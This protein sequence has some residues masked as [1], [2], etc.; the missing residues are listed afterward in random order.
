[1]KQ[2]SLLLALICLT[3]TQVSFASDCNNQDDFFKAAPKAAFVALVKVTKYLTYKNIYGEQKPI[4]MEVEIIDI[5][6]GQE[7]RKKITI[8]GGDVNI[9]RPMLHKFETGSYFV[10]ALDKVVENSKEVSH[11]GEKSSDYV[12]TN[13]GERWLRV[14]KSKGIATNWITEEKKEYKLTEIKAIFK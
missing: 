10:L 4:A 9:N 7:K 3:F 2:I 13:C 6:K 5:Y 12:I 1:M 14:D 8:W 11:V